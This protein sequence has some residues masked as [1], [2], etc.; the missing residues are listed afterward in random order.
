[1]KLTLI[2]ILI[3]V[4]GT[5][6]LGGEQRVPAADPSRLS[7]QEVLD[8]MFVREKQLVSSMKQYRPMIETYI[9]NLADN[10]E[11]GF[12]PKGD[13]YFLGKLDVTNGVNQQSLLPQ[14][15]F[16]QIMSSVLT[17]F[18]SVGY[19]PNGFAQMLLIDDTHF[20]A[21]HYS[22]EY[23]RRE[24]LGEVRCF[25]FDVQPK[26][27]ND[28]AGFLGRIWVEDRDYNLVRFNGT[29]SP[30][31]KSKSFFHFDS[32]RQQMANGQWLPAFVYSEETD[33]RYSIAR[34]KLHFKSQTRVWGYGPEETRN[35]DDS[36]QG[37]DAVD[38]SAL[39]G[40]RIWI[41]QAEN[42]VLGR[43]EKSGVLA[44]AGDVDKVLQ[45]VVTNLQITNNLSLTP[46]IRC[47][48]LLTSPLESFSVGNTIVL[49]RGLIDVL[50]DEA[51]LAMVLARELAHITL[52][53][54]IDTKYAFNDRLMFDDL[55]T[56]WRLKIKPTEKE[57]LAADQKALELLR[58][59]PYRDKLANAGLFLRA[60][61]DRA[62]QLPNLLKARLGTGFASNNRVQRMPQLIQGAPQL[63]VSR[64]D[65]VAAL[66]LG[67]R[68]NLDPWSNRLTLV[69]SNP[70]QLVS[71]REKMPFEVT[72]VILYLTRQSQIP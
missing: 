62:K 26:P 29:Y 24:F 41:R 52:A 68:L 32:W 38:A 66:P 48:V 53:H 3:L 56:L 31:G 13:Q 19:L 14:P 21:G 1:M 72:P 60:L 59:S 57:E 37:D 64:L 40:D 36:V 6:I 15:G 23:V 43:L 18:F 45:T 63:Q 70:V 42:N 50:P 25:V 65:Q 55:E 39:P 54:R 22:F 16:A 30:Q 9:Q 71:P 27:D 20:D 58:N 8:R 47:R 11:V 34:R 5:S 61:D 28:Q 67:S 51:S 33:Y 35:V 46:E 4:I 17:K 69:K 44:P 2:S 49:S 7:P 12:T 10:G